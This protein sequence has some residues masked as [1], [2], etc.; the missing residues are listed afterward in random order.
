MQQTPRMADSDLVAER[1][2]RFV[3]RAAE[4]NDLPDFFDLALV[5][6][7]GFTSLPA[8]EALLAESL[9]R[10]EAAFDGAPGSL[11]LALE[12]LDLGRV[13]GCAAIKTG[14]T[15]RP[16]FLNFQVCYD[17]DDLFPTRRYANLTEVG[18]LLVHPDYRRYGVGRWLAQCR[19]LMIADD[20]PRFGSHIFSE[21][22]GV[23]DEDKCSPFYDGVL[24]PFL[25]LTYEEADYLSAHGR[26]AE[27]NAMLPTTPIRL[28][29]VGDAA[30]TALA[31]PHRDG[32]KALWFL[33]EEGFC[34]E[35]AVDLL[36]GGPLVVAQSHDIKT[37]RTSAKLRL[38]NGDV[39][40]DDA[41]M[42]I[43]TAGKG[44]GFRSV[45]GLTARRGQSVI[46]SFDLLDDLRIEPG[47]RVRVCFGV[48]QVEQPALGMRESA[49]AEMDA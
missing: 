45:R 30:K 32:Q 40:Q 46:G 16:D 27:L 18:S 1:P 48:R 4:T 25:D 26:Q 6:G 2:P 31:S 36:D 35:G 37:I 23:I 21:L 15:P 33:E 13:V 39:D 49:T 38:D 43:L 8:N 3:I 22:R 19:Y 28:G 5:A 47:T 29:D 20:L 7:A 44:T 41:V 17:R 14:D 11:F 42:T 9:G 34:F 10:S 24:A 12:D